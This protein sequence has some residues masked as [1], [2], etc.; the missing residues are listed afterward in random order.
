MV[1]S[2]RSPLLV[3]RAWAQIAI[4]TFVIGFGI[5]GYLAYRIYEDHPPIPAAVVA[6]DAVV[7]DLAAV[8]AL[9]AAWAAP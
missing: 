4:L 2:Q 8:A 1:A 6:P 3:S 7:D 5:L 9:V